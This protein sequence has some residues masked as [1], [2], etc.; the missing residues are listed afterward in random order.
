MQQLLLCKQD[1]YPDVST[2]SSF[3]MI[4]GLIQC[5]PE[6]AVSPYILHISPSILSILLIC[7]SLLF[8]LIPALSL[9]SILI[10]FKMSLFLTFILLHLCLYWNE[11]SFLFSF[12]FP[13]AFLDWFCFIVE[14][15]QLTFE[16]LYSFHSLTCVT[17]CRLQAFKP[18][19]LFL[20]KL[21]YA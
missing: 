4:K 21:H 14:F 2:F 6:L 10:F 12:F 7:C 15:F 1:W 19:P 9:I 8:C 16:I 5:G 11:F 20:F 13:Q 3:L 18:S 17:S